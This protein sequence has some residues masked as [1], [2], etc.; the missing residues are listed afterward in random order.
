[1]TGVQIE[2]RF[3]RWAWA[4][5]PM[6]QEPVE[7]K[8]PQVLRRKAK[9]EAASEPGRARVSKLALVVNPPVS[10]GD[11]RDAGSIP[12]SGRSPGGGH[13]SSLPF[14]CLEKPTHRGAWWATVHGV[15]KS[16]TRLKR[17][18]THT[19]SRECQCV[20]LQTDHIWDWDLPHTFHWCPW[21]E[22]SQWIMEDRELNRVGSTKKRKRS[23]QIRTG[24]TWNLQ[25]LL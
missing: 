10:A 12:G 13:G 17:L 2:K 19:R 7:E 4:L 11:L 1:M 23:Q 24:C 8:E 14:S 16:Q 25:V 5:S 18:S 22:L 3:T 20:M 9:T 21:Q 15:A 6:V